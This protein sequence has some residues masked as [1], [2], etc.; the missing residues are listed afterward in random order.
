MAAINLDE[1]IA[2]R[3]EATGVEDGRIPFQFTATDGDNVGELLSFSFRDPMFLT[4]DEQD[5]LDEIALGP[6]LCAWY[7]G[8]DEY[9]RFLDA[10]GSSNLW[11]MVF[12]KHSDESAE[13]N[14]GRP[15]RPNRA[16]RRRRTR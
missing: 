3:K 1:L 14:G 5:E 6:D 10:G 13:A 12:R 15:T 16:S 4:D 8:E 9:E 11:A 7:M 2:Q